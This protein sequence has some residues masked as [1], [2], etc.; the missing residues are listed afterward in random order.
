MRDE[1]RIIFPVFGKMV[2]SLELAVS[3]TFSSLLH[4]TDKPDFFL[5]GD[6]LC[7]NRI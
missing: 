1:D 6:D 7:F 3:Q 5:N 4:L 2:H